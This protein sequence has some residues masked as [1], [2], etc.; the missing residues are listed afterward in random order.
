MRAFSLLLNFLMEPNVNY[1][2]IIRLR[3]IPFLGDSISVCEGVPSPWNLVGH[4]SLLL[5]V[6]FVTDAG[7]TVWRRG[8]RRQAV[9]VGGSIV[10][11]VLAATV[12]TML[13][14]WEVFHWPETAGL[15]F[16]GIV[17]AMTFE[18]TREV[19]WAAQLSDDLRESEGRMTLATEAAGAGLWSWDFDTGQIRATEKT[20]ELYGFSQDEKITYDKFLSTI[21]PDDRERVGHTAQQV[22]KEGAVF[23]AEYRIVLPDRSIRWITARGQ[24]YLKH[25]GEPDR[26]MGVSLDITER[27]ESEFKIVQQRNELAHLSRVTTLSELSGSL[28]HELNQPLA[29][30]LTNAQA[31][32]RLLKQ[33]PPDLAEACDILA[34]I[35]SEDQRAGEV[36]RR[37]RALLKPG[38][39]NLLPLSVN[40]IIEEVLRIARNELIARGITV[41]TA[42]VE[43]LPQAFGDRVQLQQVLLNLIL[44]A[45]DAMAANLPAHRHLTL[46]TAHRD[47]VVQISVS[48]TGCGLPPD[49]EL[50]FSPFYTTKK[51]GLGLGLSICRSIATAHNARLWAEPAVPAGASSDAV[52]TTRGT[53]FHLELPVSP[54]GKS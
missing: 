40:E 31:A 14:R 26:M 53:T 11:F 49:A 29:I 13:A 10:F 5:L 46:A 28:A 23:R 38:Q 39:T 51:D 47:G 27:K 3:H 18:L 6:I 19:L 41:H 36:I 52:T 25:S 35:V 4:L 33:Q 37:L 30:I 42:M 17:V 8:D 2:E 48:D 21:H 50:I 43:G 9:V 44:N 16:L 1:R 45:S 20:L 34:D 12:Q 24:A 7:I 15:F 22:F 54:E 32:Q